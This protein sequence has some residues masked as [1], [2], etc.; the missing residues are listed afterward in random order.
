VGVL[1]GKA[2][3][4]NTACRLIAYVSEIEV[5]NWI[6]DHDPTSD[7]DP[8]SRQEGLLPS[9]SRAKTCS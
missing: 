3:M 7:S 4:P 6:I 9:P 2:I 5:L 8:N 1:F